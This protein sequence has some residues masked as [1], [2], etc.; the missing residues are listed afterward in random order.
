VVRFAVRVR[1]GARRDAVGGRWGGKLGTAL[2]VSVAAP[3]VDGK[4]NDAVCRVLAKELGIRRQQVGIIA[5]ERSRDK[6]VA[7]ADPPEG[8]LTLVDTLIHRQ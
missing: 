3:A 7:V 1:P 6:V 5:G 8:L 4:A 2:V